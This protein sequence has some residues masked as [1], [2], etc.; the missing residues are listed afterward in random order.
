MPA[1]Y[2][3]VI[4]GG[5]INGAAVAELSAAAGLRVALL[6]R[7]DFGAGVTSRSTRLIHGGLRY[8]EHGQLGLVRESLRE[9]EALLEDFPQQVQ[10]LPFLIP[11]YRQDSRAA[12]W[13]RLGLEAY[14]WM[15]R[16]RSLARYRRLSVAELLRLEPGLN[17]VGLLSGFLYYDCQACYPERLALDMAL[18][19]EAGGADIRNHTAVTALL[20]RAGQVRGVRVAS[21]EEFPARLVINAA[22][23]WVDQVRRLP[24]QGTAPGNSRPPLLTLVSGVHLVTGPFPGAP[25][26][27]VYHEASRD[28]RPFFIIPW[29]GLWLIG[30]TET[31]HQGDPG[32]PAPTPGEIDYL[33]GETNLLLPGASLSRESILYCYAGARPLLHSG[34]RRAQ[35]MSRDHDIYDHQKREGLAGMITLAGG[36][37]TTARAFAAEALETVAA[38]L[39]RACPRAPRRPAWN[40]GAVPPRLAQ[41]YGRRSE[42][43][44]EL[45]RRQPELDRPVCPGRETTAAEVI[46]AVHR[47]KAKTLGDILLR[48]TGLAFGPCRALDCAPEIARLAAP[49]LGWD[50]AGIEK[51]IAE[52]RREVEQTLRRP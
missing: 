12:W 50:Q 11:M 19:A 3:L 16:S 24:L 41:I 35:S 5:G 1:D 30:T 38:R 4:I 46:H 2:D 29:R 36:K 32:D 6:E 42:Q 13:V 21:G 45:S 39:G 22:G 51:A 47:E 26:H 40:T 18:E 43:I 23:P 25:R 34:G 28:R 9:R 31:P 48:R 17:S 15:A 33:L 8:L 49:Y 37:L 52:Y 20:G 44:V 14:D 27:A 7:T 10:P